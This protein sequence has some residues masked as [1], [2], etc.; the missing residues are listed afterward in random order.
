MNSVARPTGITI[1]A[2]LALI[3]G[4][5]GLLAGLALIAG[6]ALIGG[7]VGGAEGAAFGGFA[8]VLGVIT[9]GSAALYLAFAYGSWTA[10]S[11]GWALGVI[12]A[13]WGLGTLAL[14]ILLSGDIVGNLISVNTIISAVIPAGILYYLNTP[15][16][17]AFFGRA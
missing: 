1:L 4:V 6:G 10:K 8:F 12:G 9:L 14:G 5:F 3:G 15:G 7:A 17:K 13:L 16:V 2:I 11:Y